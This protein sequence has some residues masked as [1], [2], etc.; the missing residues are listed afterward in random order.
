MRRIRLIGVRV[1]AVALLGACVSTNPPAP[2]P[3]PAFDQAPSPLTLTQRDSVAAQSFANQQGPRVSIRA[4]MY[5]NTGMRRVRA[6]FHADDDAYVLVGQIDAS[7]VLRIVFPASPTDNGFV[8]GQQSYQTPEFLAGFVDQFRLRYDQSYRSV[9]ANQD[10]YD[11]GLGF[12][13]VIA[14]W[15]P[16]SF[17]RVASNGYWDSY[18]VADANFL[19]DPRPAIQELAAVLAGDNSEAYTIQFARYYNTQAIY[20]GDDYASNDTPFGYGFCSGYEPGGYAPS[21]FDVGGVG[22]NPTITYGSSF[23][24]RGTAYQ[25]NYAA[26]CY[27]TGPAY[28]S[29]FGY[30]YGYGYGNGWGFGFGQGFGTPPIPTRPR[31]LGFGRPVG[32]PMAVPKLRL[33]MPGAQDVGDGSQ[34]TTS[35]AQYRSRG[36]LT[37]GVS[38]PESAPVT[39]GQHIVMLTPTDGASRPS[40]QQ[41]VNRHGAYTHEASGVGRGTQATTQSFA[42]PSTGT[43]QHPRSEPMSTGQS[44]IYTRPVPT[45]ESPR[46]APP[47]RVES[48][49]RVA[50][51]MR[52]EAP[53]VETPRS[54]PPA[55]SSSSG[56]TGGKP[57][58]KG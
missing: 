2:E 53:R 57:P 27:T 29:P 23:I 44:R 28:Y 46:V 45:G 50:P 54:P 21:P 36:L 13:F 8:H 10:S 33:P 4:S 42:I 51:P 6:N 22:F 1:S 12:V 55:S 35:S 56:S 32:Q 9:A 40:I 26:D 47:P 15:R 17:D 3:A 11:G 18:E 25:Y 58:G 39:H 37:S 34:V 20:T 31:I 16:M 38:G 19:V 5:S 49:P 48:A 43:Q 41:M 7:G 30:G 52:V 14:S 24:W